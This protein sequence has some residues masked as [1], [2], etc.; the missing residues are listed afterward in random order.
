MLKEKVANMMK[1]AAAGMMLTLGVA[2]AAPAAQVQADTLQEVEPNDNPA[3]AT[4][5]PLNIWIKGTIEDWNEQDWYVIT[6][7]QAGVSQIEIEPTIDNISGSE[8]NVAVYDAN[9][10]GRRN[11]CRNYER[12]SAKCGKRLK[13]RTGRKKRNDPKPA[14]NTAC[15]LSPE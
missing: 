8:W 3:E 9:I 11:S 13:N 10:A 14:G 5:L 4:K 7:P 1:L 2:A 12:G 15:W 6:I